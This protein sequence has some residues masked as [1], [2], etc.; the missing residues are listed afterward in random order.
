MSVIF[1]LNFN[2]FASQSINND[3]ELKINTYPPLLQKNMREVFQFKNPEWATI[4]FKDLEEIEKSICSGKI[5]H[6]IPAPCYNYVFGLTDR[7]YNSD[8]YVAVL[9]T[10]IKVFIKADSGHLGEILVYKFSHNLG[11]TLVPPTSYLKE[12][13]PPYD[14]M[15]EGKSLEEMKGKSKPL[16]FTAQFYIEDGTHFNSNVEEY[17]EYLSHHN[18]S[19]RMISDALLFRMFIGHR[20]GGSKV[21]GRNDLVCTSN[22]QS[23]IALID[24]ASALDLGTEDLSGL[25]SNV[26]DGELL[27][28]YFK[29][30]IHIEIVK[31]FESL[32]KEK[33]F[34]LFNS[35]QE[36]SEFI[37]TRREKSWVDQFFIQ[38]KKLITIINE[39]INSIKMDGEE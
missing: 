38:K 32:N 12:K 20:D 6:I 4:N 21:G 24:N 14:L 30:G 36:G 10:N 17:E 5:K 16:I 22:S 9:D 2:S 11:L 29:D 19:K 15:F 28:R 33:L 31:K 3:I 34:E 18:L 23:K 26:Y 27:S 39:R 8:Q 25:F 1:V 7:R 35:F 37:K 13:T